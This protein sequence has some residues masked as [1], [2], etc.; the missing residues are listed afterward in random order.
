MELEFV[1]MREM[2]G[3]TVGRV[4]EEDI[5]SR[6][7]S[8]LRDDGLCWCSNLVD[9]LALGCKSFE[10]NLDAFRRLTEG[11]HVGLYPS[12]DE[13]PTIELY[14]GVAATFLQQGADGIYA[15]NWYPV[16]AILDSRAHPCQEQL[17]RQALCEMGSPDTLRH[18]DKL[19]ATQRRG[20]GGWPE[21]AEF[22]Y[23]NTSAFAQLPKAISVA[24]SRHRAPERT[25]GR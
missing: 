19:F 9:I 18:K 17:R 22:F 7:I 10:I 8:Y 3:L 6:L 4:I 23:K 21:S 16:P 12:M 25:G 5:R 24:P 11:T 14:R 2:S 20:G 13:Q 15:F 1:Y